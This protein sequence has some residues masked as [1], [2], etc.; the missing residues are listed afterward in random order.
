MHWKKIFFSALIWVQRTLQKL[1]GASSVGVRILV[2]NDKQE[3]LLVEHTYIEGWHFP[4][5][6]VKH[7]EPLHSAA[8]RE[9]FEETGV[10]AQGDLTLFHVYVHNIH[11]VTDYP[12]LFISKHFEVTSQKKH[13]PEI[14]A[15]RWFPLAHLPTDI[16]QNTYQR[17]QEYLG[18][19]PIQDRW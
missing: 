6:G 10:L 9:L 16:T 1:L 5:G 14:K 2:I 18:K 3:V 7:Q 19:S 17:I 15:V 4:G 12:S 8:K 11:G 13:S